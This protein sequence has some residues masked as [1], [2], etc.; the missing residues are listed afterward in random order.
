MAET[1][2]FNTYI[3][4]QP[5]TGD[6]IRRDYE[7]YQKDPFAM[8]WD[9]LTGNKDSTQGRMVSAAGGGL[10]PTRTPN[11]AA[12]L[13]ASMQLQPDIQNAAASDARFRAGLAQGPR[14][15]PYNMGVADQSRGAQ[16]ALLQQMRNQMAGPSIANMQGQR[17]LGQ[18]GQQA[19]MGASMGGPGGR[20]GMLQAG[21]VGG[22]LA[23]DVGQA[24]LAELM[25]AQAGMG[26]LAGSL[27]GNDLRSADAQMR[28]AID[29][30]GMDDNMRRFYASQGANLQNA[31][32]QAI[33][34]REGTRLQQLTKNDARDMQNAQNFMG[35]VASMAGGIFG[36]K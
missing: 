15:S 2:D 35:S 26:G 24:R 4:G 8:L 9:M 22:G 1:S 11:E 17:A 34:N 36:G 19:L 31:R 3:G 6:D 16:M 18:S 5:M 32:D 12:A 23:G 25:R 10:N 33:A 30:R 13:A 20:A 7:K 27:R 21:Q 14:Q 28:Q 29:M